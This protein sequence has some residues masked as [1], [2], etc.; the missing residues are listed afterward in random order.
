MHNLLTAILP[1]L[2]FVPQQ[3]GAAVSVRPPDKATIRCLGVFG[4]PEPLWKQ[5]RKLSDYHIN[6]VFMGHDQVT[7][8]LI[9]RCHREGAKVYAEFGI[10]E[11][12]DTATKYADL[13]PLNEQGE[14]QKQD[15]WYL[16]LCPHVKWF[17]DQKID[18]LGKF[19]KEHA[20]DGLWLDFIR[21]PGHWEVHEPHLEQG[22]FNAPCLKAFREFSG[23]TLPEGTIAT[24]AEFILT[25]H[26]AEWT[27]FKC[28]TILDFCRD[29]RRTLKAA[30]PD[31]LLGAFV[32]PWTE[33]NYNDAIHE[34][35]AQDFA[36]LAEA[37]DVFSP[38]SYHA[39]CGFPVEWVG[40]FNEYLTAR[41]HRD[42]WPIVQ[43][44]EREAR[45]GDAPVD[46]AVFRQTLTQGL[47]GGSTGVLMFTLTDCTDAN[48]KL[49]VVQDVYG[50]YAR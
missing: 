3:G 27:K 22:C 33:D 50:E 44:T 41:T 28:E 46:A 2:P 49:Q 1:L 38:M 40:R 5:G 48:G 13:W 19:A 6:A 25:Q 15:E 23:L 8:D 21:Y 39:M 37:L 7:E 36:Q 43:A 32:V 30:R 17:R 26:K 45:Y 20:I 16:G 12:P 34:T 47:S 4:S 18:L 14:K 35:I 24:K 10:F 42:V 9:R 29:A 31:A 11:G